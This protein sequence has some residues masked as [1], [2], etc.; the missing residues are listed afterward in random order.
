M[1]ARIVYWGIPGAGKSTNLTA[2]ERKLRA[3]HRGELRR[4]PTPLDPSTS[5]EV[6]PIS[7][8]NVGGV[9]TRIQIVA[10]PGAP[11]QAPT[12]KQLLD[13]VDGIVL[14]I[15]SRRESIDANLA[16]FDELRS[17]MA[18]YGRSLDD[19]PLVLQYNK[20]D[21][22][23]PYALEELHRKLDLPGSGAFEA[24][25]SEGTGV[26][27]TLTTVSKQVIRALR[28]PEADPEPA[29]A[30]E[31]GAEPAAEAGESQAVEPMEQPEPP[32]P[33]EAEPGSEAERAADRAEDLLGASW[34]EVT[35][36][37]GPE[38]TRETSDAEGWRVV[39][40]GPAHVGEDGELA[41]PLVLEDG[42][43]RQT[44]LRLRLALEA[45]DALEESD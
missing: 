9:P 23:D 6:L 44:R 12:R 21:V 19:V 32:A 10:V 27:E 26:I 20:R 13:R 39:E 43:G 15:D 35:A 8:G 24:V 14:V 38:P 11:E 40:T 18:A 42:E 29:P 33:R 7:I 36:S 5:Y 2:L 37:L 1:E 28:R 41:L 45:D 4:V 25:A 34:G 17:A 3:D 22:S 31:P 30:T 16:G